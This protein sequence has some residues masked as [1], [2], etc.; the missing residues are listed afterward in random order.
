MSPIVLSKETN[1]GGFAVKKSLQ[2]AALLVL[3]TALTASAAIVSVVGGSDYL[4]T[5][6]GTTFGGVAFNGV[7]VGPGNT[8]T[9]VRRLDNAIFSGGTASTSIQMMAL[10]LVSA[11]PV[12]FGLGTDFY[13]ITLQSARGGPDTTGRMTITLSS[14]DDHLPNTP[15]G[16]FSSFFDVFFDVRKGGLNGAIALSSDLVLTNT[17]AVWDAD[18]A[19]GQ[20][21]VPGLVGDLS[22][23]LHTNKI[24]NVDIYQMDFFPIGV[25]TEAH[26]TGALHVVGGA[27]GTSTTSTPEPTSL[28]LVAGGAL[29][30]MGRLRRR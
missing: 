20:V 26:P 16:T 18:P 25:F 9:I 6:P 24:Q 4:A 22:A 28:L 12:D 17:G 1:E 3:V 21:I 27:T 7:P 5:Q 10:D 30:L 19:P 14:P 15:E 11:V 13:Y 2:F 23:N 29:I 8:D